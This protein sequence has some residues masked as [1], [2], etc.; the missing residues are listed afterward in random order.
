[1]NGKVQQSISTKQK[2]F[3]FWKHDPRETNKQELKLQQMLSKRKLQRAKVGFQEQ[4]LKDL[5]INNKIF[6][7]CLR[8]KRPTTEFVQAKGVVKEDNYTVWKLND[9]NFLFIQVSCSIHSGGFCSLYSFS[10]NKF[11]LWIVTY[12][13]LAT[14]EHPEY[15]RARRNM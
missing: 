3:K 1:M 8:N 11:S 12:Q 2:S 14:V 13:K 10:S 15:I 5:K 6:L 4:T 9:F 7:R